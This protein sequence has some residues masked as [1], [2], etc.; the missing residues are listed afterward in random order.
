[1]YNFHASASAYMQFWNDCN[2]ITSSTVQVTCHQIWHAF[3]QES[4]RTISSAQRTHLELWEDLT[5]NQVVTQAFAKLGNMKLE[6]NIHVQSVARSTSSLQML[7][8]IVMLLI[9]KILL[10]SPIRFE[11]PR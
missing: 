1:M 9:E 6:K 8:P 4:L 11:G 5:I 10:R 7:W 3:V 2:S